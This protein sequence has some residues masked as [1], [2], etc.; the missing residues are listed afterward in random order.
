M[1]IAVTSII[2]AACI[3]T[4]AIGF[5]MGARSEQKISDAWKEASNEW[6]QVAK[7]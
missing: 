3:L 4:F 6:K 2:V 7:K 1:F 5:F